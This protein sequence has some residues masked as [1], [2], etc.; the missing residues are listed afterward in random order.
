[1]FP[2]FCNEGLDMIE[3]GDGA[4]SSTQ[5]PSKASAE[6][7]LEEGVDLN[8]GGGEGFL[9]ENTFSMRKESLAFAEET[10]RDTDAPPTNGANPQG[11]YASKCRRRSRL[12]PSPPRARALYLNAVDRPLGLRRALR[13]KERQ[14]LTTNS[15]T[16]T[17]HW[18]TL[19]P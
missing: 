14:Q 9:R 5:Q 7:I 3:E 13:C 17:A 11:N 1:M 19:R 4:A 18:L 16:G 8:F 15:S 10:I 2:S 6:R 12:P